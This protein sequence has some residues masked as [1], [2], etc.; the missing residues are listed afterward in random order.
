MLRIDSTSRFFAGLGELE[1]DNRIR[2]LLNRYADFDFRIDTTEWTFRFSRVAQTAGTMATVEDINERHINSRYLGDLPINPALKATS[3][4]AEA[5]TQ[6]DVLVLGVPS[7]ATRAVLSEVAEHLRPWVPVVSLVKGLEQG[8]RLRIT[9][10]V[11]EVLPGHPVGVLNG[12]NI[13]REIVQGY[14][15][16][17]TLAMP[18]QQLAESLQGILRSTM[19][20]VYT[21][22]D[23]V[24]VDPQVEPLQDRGSL[25]VSHRRA[26]ERNHR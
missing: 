12:P 13:A 2:P 4:L 21:S 25:A 9:E 11:S 1:M 17:A 24:G 22:T 15:A 26:I 16:A 3:D 6:A 20:R 10:V 23:V 7:Q 8:S 5:V 14:A 18:D 19:F